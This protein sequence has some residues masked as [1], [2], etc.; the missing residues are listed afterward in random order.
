MTKRFGVRLEARGY[1]TTVESDGSFF[2]S[3]GPQGGACA[4]RVKSDTFIQ[5]ELLAGAVFAF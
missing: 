2:C 5:Y 4:I 1:L 3:S